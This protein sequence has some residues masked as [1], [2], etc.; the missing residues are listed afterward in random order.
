MKKL[1]ANLNCIVT[2]E[3]LEEQQE[4]LDNFEDSSPNIDYPAIRIQNSNHSHG[5]RYYNAEYYMEKSQYS[6]YEFL[7][8]KEFKAKYL[9][10]F[11]LPERWC[12]LRTKENH[13]IINTWFK[14][15]NYGEPYLN[16]DYITIKGKDNY[17]SPRKEDI[18]KGCTIITFEQFEKYVMKKEEKEIIGYKAPIDMFNSEVKKGDL[19]ISYSDNDD[20]Y[21]PK[22][23]LKQGS[24]YYSMPKELVQSTWEAVY[25]QQEYRG[26]VKGSNKSLDY[27]I[28]EQGFV[29]CDGKKVSITVLKAFVNLHNSNLLP[30]EGMGASW[31][32]GCLEDVT[33]EE[34]NDIVTQ[35]NKLFN[36]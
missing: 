33:R 27:V 4:L 29:Q 17:E 21:A 12:V 22:I 35:H 30:W 34:L 14:N 9:E 31:H 28:N 24:A 18:P 19:Y 11:V 23:P 15:N 26:V 36:L 16:Y 25:K 10:E 5:E 6:H 7:T 8:F 1:P 20:L 2:C 13:K 3:N 32:I